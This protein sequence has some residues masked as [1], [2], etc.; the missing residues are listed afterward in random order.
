MA[1]ELENLILITSIERP[2]YISAKLIV[3]SEWDAV[4]KLMA[5][6]GH[7]TTL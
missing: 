7:Y 1:D 2:D 4:T 6:P 3:K 5:E